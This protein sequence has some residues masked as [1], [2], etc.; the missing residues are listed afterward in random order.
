MAAEKAHYPMRLLCRSLAVSR[1][2]YY[3]WAGRGPSARQLTDARLTAQLR[4]VHAD[5]RQTY[6][7]PRL[8]HA[9]RARGI[10]VSPKRVARLM[11]AAGL[12]ARG[13]RRFRLTTDS[14]HQYPIAPNRLRRRFAVSRTNR[15]WAA[16]LTACWTRE[17]WCYLAVGLDLASR[18]VI[19][20]AVRRAANPEL[21]IAALTPALSRLRQPARLLHHSDRGIQYASQAYQRVLERYHIRC[22]M[23]RRRDCWDNAP[24]ESFF[25]TLKTELLPE[26]PWS[27]AEDAAT[28]IADYIDFYNRRRLHSSLDYQSPVDFEAAV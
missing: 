15:V 5:S 16:D 22:S 9:L 23:S 3:A 14:G 1:S 6:G 4:L 12:C 19:G 11:R 26:R 2:G 7:R 18:R 8:C 28:A 20:W 25:S 17:G 13:R 21:V 24:V 10:T 27:D